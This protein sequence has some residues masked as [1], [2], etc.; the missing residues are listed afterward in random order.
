MLLRS[1]GFT[2]FEYRPV[3]LPQLDLELGDNS[4]LV[5]SLDEGRTFAPLEDTAFEQLVGYLGAP[6]GFARKLKNAV[7][8]F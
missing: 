1:D 4:N 8:R 3:T 2:P 5:V 7:N 6:V